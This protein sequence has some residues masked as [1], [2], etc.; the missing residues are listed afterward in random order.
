M[1]SWKSNSKMNITT[2][3]SM[4]KCI[5]TKNLESNGSSLVI[6][7]ILYFMPK[8]SLDERKIEFTS[9]SSPMVLGLMIAPFFKVRLKVTIKISSATTIKVRF[10]LSLMETIQP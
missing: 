3:S 5:G 7:T 8:P 1:S 9:F 4:K 10:F 6:E 2:F